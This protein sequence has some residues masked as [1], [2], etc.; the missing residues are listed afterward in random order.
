MTDMLPYPIPVAICTL[1]AGTPI[2]G[3]LT[4]VLRAYC[5]DKTV[6]HSRFWESY[7]AGAE[8]QRMVELPLHRRC[9][10]AARFAVIEGHV[11][12]ILQAQFEADPHGM[13]IT[14]LSL[15][16]SEANYDVSGI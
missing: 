6:Y 5:R 10:E 12:E 16:R 8:I 15:R 2:Q 4:Q 14:T 7:Q 13:P 3:K 9:A 11:Y 1:A